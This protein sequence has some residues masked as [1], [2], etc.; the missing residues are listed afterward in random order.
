MGCLKSGFG[1]CHFRVCSESIVLIVCFSRLIYTEI[2][3]GKRPQ[4]IF[5][6][7]QAAS[8]AESNSPILPHCVTASPSRRFL[9]LTQCKPGRFAR[10]IDFQRIWIVRRASLRGPCCRSHPATSSSFQCHAEGRHDAYRSTT[11]PTR[12]S[13]RRTGTPKVPPRGR[14]LA[15]STCRRTSG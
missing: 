5:P 14:R 15:R 8:S 11:S 13:H 12:K 2:T 3:R 6:K 7:I 10:S 9:R 1:P 4:R